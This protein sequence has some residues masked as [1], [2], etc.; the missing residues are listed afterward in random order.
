M[1]FAVRM[2]DAPDAAALR[3]E[4]LA[5]HLDY[6]GRIMANIMV[7]GPLAA[8]GEAAPGSLAVIDVP[9][10]AALEK[11]IADDPYY[12]HGVWSAFDAQPYDPVVGA[13]VVGT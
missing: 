10:R 13:W 9:D 6:V 7:A 8:D 12:R 4:H 1:K 3:A 5:E 11:L 2:Y